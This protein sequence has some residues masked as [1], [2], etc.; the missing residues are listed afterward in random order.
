[1]ALSV[2]MLLFAYLVIVILEALRL[3]NIRVWE[4]ISLSV[5][6][7]FGGFCL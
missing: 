1:M 3:Q 7:P 4:N 2:Q 5:E 6:K